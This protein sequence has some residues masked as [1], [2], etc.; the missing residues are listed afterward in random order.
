MRRF[1]TCFRSNDVCSEQK[2]VHSE[3]S[4]SGG[5]NSTSE[6]EKFENLKVEVRS[7]R[8]EG[9]NQQSLNHQPLRLL[10]LK[11]SQNTASLP[12]L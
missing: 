1:R 2:K 6:S 12:E 5:W 10:K 11:V 8:F 3:Q 9:G 7:E 4:D